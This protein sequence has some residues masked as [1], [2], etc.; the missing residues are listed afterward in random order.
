MPLPRHHFGAAGA[1]LSADTAFADFLR[2]FRVITEYRFLPVSF[3]NRGRRHRS[4]D[5]A[6]CGGCISSLHTLASRHGGS[7]AACKECGFKALPLHQRPGRDRYSY[8]CGRGDC[9]PRWY[10]YF[11][12]S[13]RATLLKTQLLPKKNNNLLLLNVPWYFK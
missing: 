13:Q 4:F 3:A 2:V 9:E 5:S 12:H 11:L 7:L 6:L 1:D 10:N 8:H